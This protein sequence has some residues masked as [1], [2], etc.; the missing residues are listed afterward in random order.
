VSCGVRLRV[1]VR[2]ISPVIVRRVDV[3]GW[4]SLVQLHEMLL[5]CFGWSGEC[6]HVFDI[7]GRSYSASGYVDAERPT[8]SSGQTCDIN[9]QSCH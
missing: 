6:L 3:S 2:G 4:V 5:A 9:R 7:R 8:G 1:V